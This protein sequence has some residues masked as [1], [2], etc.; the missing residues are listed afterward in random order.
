MALASIRR[1]IA[2]ERK[3]VADKF[4]RKLSH[5]EYLRHCGR[6]EMLEIVANMVQDAVRKANSAASEGS[7]DPDHET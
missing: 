5:E 4:P 2:D 3:A 1:A 7:D 6:H